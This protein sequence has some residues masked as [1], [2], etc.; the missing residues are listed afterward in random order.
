MVRWTST[1]ARS[2]RVQF[3]AVAG[4]G[5]PGHVRI[6]L[7]SSIVMSPVAGEKEV[8][9]VIGTKPGVVSDPV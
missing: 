3:D 5:S 1:G 4:Y 7:T 2:K 8:L 6:G 9:N